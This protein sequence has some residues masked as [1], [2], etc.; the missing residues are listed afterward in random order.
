MAVQF[1]SRSNHHY[2]KEPDRTPFPALWSTTSDS[3]KLAVALKEIESLRAQLEEAK[4]PQVS[5]LRKRGTAGGAN[6]PANKP[7]QAVATA[8]QQGVP[9]EIVIGLMVGVFVLTYLFF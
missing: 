3:E 7:A 1:P 8:Q 4:G 6:E 5:G 9:L 2:G